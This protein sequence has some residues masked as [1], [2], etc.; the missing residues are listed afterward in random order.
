VYRPSSHTGLRLG[1]LALAALWP[2][3]C[4]PDTWYEV[5]ASDP[6]VRLPLDESPHCSGGEW[7]YY[8]G[9]LQTDDA[10]GYG[11]E[12]VIFHVP[13][14]VLVIPEQG[15]AA[16]FAV[17]D[18]SSGAFRYDQVRAFEPG[19]RGSRP[20]DGFDLQTDLVRMSG[21]E[22][23][24]HLQAAMLDG[25]YSI[26]LTLED[27][28][29]PILHGGDGYV[30]YGED[31][32]SF[33]Y[34]RPRMQA[35]GTLLIDGQPH[36]AEGTL[37]FDR[38]WG[39]DVRNPWLSWDWFSIRLD[40]DTEVMLFVFR[41]ENPHVAFGTY[42]PAAG[43][44]VPLN[45]DDFAITPTAWWTSPHTGISYPVGWEVSAI[46]QD[47]RL[48]ITAV[49]DDQELDVRASTLNV[50]WE[51]LCTVAGTQADGP[52]SGLAIVELTN[53]R[54]ASNNQ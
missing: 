44:A 33:Y 10:R 23:H 45:G 51:G 40:N 50:Y 41:G 28:R 1:I 35:R 54:S 46:A 52:V 9:R 27:Q 6:T 14:A 18:E 43:D 24:D 20:S 16:H 5:L 19:G 37:W 49:A 17:L 48:T 26:D 11:I 42:V 53:Y 32:R 47:L 34:S 3:G 39:R 15:W 36:Q 31:G 13:P 25:S 7:W 4:C 2:A 21:S 29:G 12:A 8:S 30:P 22:G 38:Q